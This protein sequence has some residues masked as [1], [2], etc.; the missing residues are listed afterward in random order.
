[1]K[2]ILGLGALSLEL[3]S[4]RLLLLTNARGVKGAPRVIVGM[5][6]GFGRG[7]VGMVVT[8]NPRINC[9]SGKTDG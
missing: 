8:P 1:M 6:R 4:L 5:K 3:F 2:L 9:D 7:H